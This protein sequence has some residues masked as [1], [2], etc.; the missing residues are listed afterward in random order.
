M[1]T[2]LAL[3]AASVALEPPQAPPPTVYCLTIAPLSFVACPVG[4][5][6]P[7]GPAGPQGPQGLPGP[8]NL[9]GSLVSAL[10]P[11]QI[12]LPLSDGTCAPLAIVGPNNTLT[13]AV[14]ASAPGPAGTAPLWAYYADNPGAMWVSLAPSTGT[15]SAP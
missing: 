12:C 5:P 11:N 6:G 3:L 1:K 15:P 9:K 8:A 10:K 4:A 2:L 14:A 7:A 13:A